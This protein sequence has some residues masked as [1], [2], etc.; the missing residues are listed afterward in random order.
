MKNAHIVQHILRAGQYPCAGL[1]KLVTPHTQVI[2]NPA[3]QRKYLLP[4][5]QTQAGCYE[6]TAFLSGLHYQNHVR[7][8]AYDTVAHREIPG[9]GFLIRSELGKD[10]SPERNRFIQIIIA[11]GITDVHAA[12]KDSIRPPLSFQCALMSGPIYAQGQTADNLYTGSCQLLSHKSG[13]L[14]TVLRTVP[15]PYDGCGGTF[16]IR[17]L[18][19]NIKSHGIVINMQ[20]PFGIFPVKGCYKTDS[21]LL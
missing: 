20:K 21:L 15:G 2:R 13:C 8:A 19:F 11:P 3:R 12:P 7:K 16:L 17:Q 14:S 10:A 9:H 18:S 4:L 5:F 1:Y 6:G